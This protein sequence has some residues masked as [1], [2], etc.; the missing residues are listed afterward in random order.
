MLIRNITYQ[1]R[2][3]PF[4]IRKHGR[5]AT[6][7]FPM[8]VVE[9]EGPEGEAEYLARRVYVLETGWTQGLEERIQGDF[10]KWL[11][12]AKKPEDPKTTLDDLVEAINTLTD[13]VMGGM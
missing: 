7:V 13:I 10:S 11:A 5:M 12:N 8:D 1:E 6:V 4:E 9:A 2:P 3:A